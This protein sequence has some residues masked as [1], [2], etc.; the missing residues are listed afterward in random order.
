[1]PDEIIQT[2]ETIDE[3]AMQ[4][5]VDAGVFCGRTKMMT[6]PRMRPYI[7]TTRNNVEIIHMGKTLEKLEEVMVFIK[8]KAAAKVP[9]L[10]VGAQ[11]ASQ[12]G[13]LGLAK[14]FSLPSVTV[15]WLGGTLTN[16]KVISR[17]VEYFK[18]LKA[19]WQSGALDKYTKKEKV[20]IQKELEKMEE[21]MSGLEIMTVRPELL[22]V[23]DPVAHKSAVREARK[24]KIP[25]VAY[26][27][28]D[29]NPDDVDYFV[30]GNTK[31]R[32]SIN[33]FISKIGDAI[34]DGQKEAAAVAAMVAKKKEEALAEKPATK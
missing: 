18:K 24:L 22:I 34:R 9:M 19:D 14:E 29:T 1:M 31:A 28:T 3:P 23:I 20:G 8:V 13:L 30:P 4:E 15:R 21:L 6:Q 27:N 10:L 33:W 25:I 16:Y 32:A 26:V 17:R 7:L 2:I 12:G 11:P 5:M